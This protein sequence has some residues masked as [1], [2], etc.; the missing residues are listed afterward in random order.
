MASGVAALVWAALVGWNPADELRAATADLTAQPAALRATTRYASL[1]HLDEAELA[2]AETALAL[3]LNATSRASAVRRPQRVHGTRLWRWRLD[4]YAPRAEDLQAWGTAYEQLA[5]EEPYWHVRTRVIDPAGGQPREVFT[6]GGWVGLAEAARLRAMSG[7]AGALMRGDWLIAKLSAPPH[8]YAF[9]GVPET[10][11]EF[12][13]RLGIDAV[14]IDRLGGDEGANLLR[15][16]VTRQVRRIVRRQGPLGGAW[17]TFD[18]AE[19]TA[20]SDPFRN[21][22]AFAYDAGEHIAAKANGLHVY[23]LFDAAGK[24]QNDVPAAIAR[25]TSD[26]HGDGLVTPM[27]SCVRCHVEG[28]LRPFV[29]DQRLLLE[30]GLDVLA[31]S[32]ARAERLAQFYAGARLAKALP[33]DR[34]DYAAAVQAATGVEA[35]AA[36]EA[37]AATYR[38][39]VYE[40]VTPHRASREL[41]LSAGVETA[42]ER[43]GDALAVLRG[44]ADPVLLAL[45]AGM[46][47][48]RAAWEASFAEAALRA[49]G[50]WSAE[51]P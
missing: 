28:G 4:E 39:Q 22:F 36:A 6:D 24:R 31:D 11:T 18:V 40:L 48:Q 37:L 29:N 9:A 47:V 38:R 30:A 17:E 2:E 42:A 45:A 50:R 25:D 3:V 10:R 13:R 32:A 33:R 51:T 7:S 5:S 34:E 16:N 46:S 26:P 8:Y 12:L 35:R 41:G 44:S 49:A 27:I 1:A 23:A 20:E 14:E 43:A 19:S 21:L 15:S